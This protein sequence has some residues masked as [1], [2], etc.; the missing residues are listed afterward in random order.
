MN[1][2]DHFEADLKQIALDLELRLA[3]DRDWANVGSYRL[4]PQTSLKPVL[5]FDFAW[6]ADHLNVTGIV[7]SGAIPAQPHYRVAEEIDQL[8]RDIVRFLNGSDW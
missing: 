1:T 6:Q 8:E 4:M 7:P 3:I 5:A 2:Q